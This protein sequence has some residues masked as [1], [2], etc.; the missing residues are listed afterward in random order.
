M[1]DI[2]LK[3]IDMNLGGRGIL[4]GRAI[5]L[6]GILSFWDLILNFR[7]WFFFKVWIFEFGAI[8]SSSI[9]SVKSTYRFLYI[10]AS[11]MDVKSREIVQFL[12]RM[13]VFV[14]SQG[15]G[16]LM[17]TASGQYFDSP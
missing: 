5:F 7:V 13:W 11:A 12:L 14:F 17:A 15:E 6:W 10:K 9:Y 16:L 2:I 8:D 4:S 3:V 1:H